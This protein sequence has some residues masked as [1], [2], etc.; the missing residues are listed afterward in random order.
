MIFA[1]SLPFAKSFF[2]ATGLP[3]T[4]VALL[5]R[6][7]VACLTTVQSAS[8]AAGAIR[9]D[10]RHRAQM[11]RFLARRGWSRD[12]ATLER[13][14]VLLLQACAHEPGTWLF[15][16]DQ[17]CKSTAGLRAAN[18][19]CP[20]NT[21]K[22]PRHSR[23]RQK[24][25]PP[26]RSHV[27]VCGLLI[28]P[29]SGTRI[30]RWQPYYTHEYCRSRQAR[31]TA[32]RP[33]PRFRTQADIAADL[34][35]DLR[36]PPGQPV[37]VLGDTAFEAKQIR[38]ACAARGF[39]WVTP[40]NPERVLAGKKPRR[41][42]RCFSQDFAAE[43]MTRIELCPGLGDWWRHQRGSRMKAWR[44]QYARRYWARAETLD[45]H[46]VGTVRAVFSTTIQPQPGQAVQVQKV[47][48]TDQVHWE[49]ERVVAAYAARWQVELFFKEMKSDLGLD[50][51]RVRDFEE[52]EGWVQACAVAFC[53]LEWYRGR[54]HSASPRPEW[55]FRQRTRGLA[56]Q[57]RQ[58]IEAADLD[59][60]AEGL[61]TGAGRQWLRERLR[62]AVPREQR[63]PA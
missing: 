50:R 58:D 35:R 20:R 53:Y 59:R 4:S 3:A 62:Q 19:Y 49:A 41:R 9:T 61:A 10:P 34:I 32:A 29:Q 24:K 48:L 22:R 13:L 45:V 36:V 37:L 1:T 39:H 18:T 12:W 56:V 25:T 31:A 11:V 26:L 40:A 5:T 16:L 33:A 42:L 21:K 27:F 51:Y 7:V 38:A 2:A 55:W 14:A 6:F 47:L 28:S 30:P 17:T 8:Q 46:H 52:V 44:G 23:R 43:T 15:V 57:V 60:I 63:R 54:Q